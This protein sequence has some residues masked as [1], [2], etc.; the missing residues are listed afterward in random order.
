LSNSVLMVVGDVEQLS[1]IRDLTV[2]TRKEGPL[3]IL[4]YGDVGRM[5]AKALSEYGISPLIVDRRD[6]E[7]IPF[8]HITGDATLEINLIGANI[9]EAV[10]VLILL[11]KDSDAIYAALLAKNLNPSAF[12]VARANHVKSAEKIYRAGADYVASVPIVASHMLAKI[13]QDEEEELALLYED[14][15]LELFTVGKKSDMAGRTLAEIDLPGRFGCRPV[16]LERKG[17]AMAMLEGDT[18]VESGDILALIG[19]QE[20]IEALNHA[21]YRKPALERMLKIPRRAKF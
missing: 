9:R 18:L 20:S 6:L 2:G 11:N 14:L 19:S 8:E 17:Q 4:G 1:R 21:Y 16:A 7:A 15:E 13:I 5:V 3:I 10:G 12:V